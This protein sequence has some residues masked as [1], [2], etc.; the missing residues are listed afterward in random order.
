M[1]TSTATTAPRTHSRARRVRPP[2]QYWDFRTL[3]WES[4]PP[5]VPAP[6]A[7]D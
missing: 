2:D 5:T 7:G 1:T 6:R 3:S 4:A